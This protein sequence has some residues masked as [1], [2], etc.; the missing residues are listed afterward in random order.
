MKVQSQSALPKRLCNI[1]SRFL[2]KPRDHLEHKEPST[3]TKATV[4][5]CSVH[6][7][8]SIICGHVSF[9]RHPTRLVK[10]S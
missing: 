4:R 10:L 2:V 8:V 9:Q 1:S 6:V 5:F 3:D 7:P